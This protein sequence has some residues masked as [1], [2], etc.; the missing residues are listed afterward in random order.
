MS[1]TA[2]KTIPAEAIAAVPGPEPAAAARPPVAMAEHVALPWIIRLRFVLL[3]G[4]IALVA[5]RH[6]SFHPASAAV[7]IGLQLLSNFW[8]LRYA[9]TPQGSRRQVRHS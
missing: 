4:E 7:P 5:I 3:A 8:L 1:L 9:R 6:S 2:D